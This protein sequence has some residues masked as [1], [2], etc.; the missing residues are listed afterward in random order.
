MI[1][2]RIDETKVEG[3]ASSSWEEDEAMIDS[4]RTTI[5]VKREYFHRGA[6]NCVD[7]YSNFGMVRYTMCS[8]LWMIFS[9]FSIT[10]GIVIERPRE[11][12]MRIGPSRLNGGP[13]RVPSWHVNGPAPIL[14]NWDVVFSYN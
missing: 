7:D 8:P 11:I 12:L 1:G 4:E 13:F 3:A 5:R 2:W 9:H 6:T 10:V 14:E